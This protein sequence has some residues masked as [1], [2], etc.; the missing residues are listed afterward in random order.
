MDHFDLLRAG[1]KRS[2]TPVLKVVIP[3]FERHWVQHG[4]G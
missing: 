3:H 2:A 4:G 1:E